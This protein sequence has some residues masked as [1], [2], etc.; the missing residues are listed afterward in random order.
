MQFGSGGAAKGYE[1]LEGQVLLTPETR[2]QAAASPQ[3][4]EAIPA[5]PAAPKAGKAKKTTGESRIE[6][7][8]IIEAAIQAVPAPIAIGSK[9]AEAPPPAAAPQA[10]PP[11]PRTAP[12]PSSMEQVLQTIADGFEDDPA[13][14]PLDRSVKA[15]GVTLTLM[16]ICRREGLVVLKLAVSNGAGSDFFVRSFAVQAEGGQLASR[17]SFRILVEP[18]RTREGYV[19]FEKPRTGAAVQIALKEDGGKGRSLGLAIPYPF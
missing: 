15:D 7:R 17:F 5:R 10:A 6:P 16:A 19:V 13:K 2:S 11:A 14:Y 12:S 3:S 9:P 4:R 18:Q 8:R 1:K